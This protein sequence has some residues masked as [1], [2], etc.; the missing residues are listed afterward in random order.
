MNT[1]LYI[2]TFFGM[3]IEVYFILLLL[4][5]LTFFFWRWLLKK[6]IKA[7]RT[8]KLAT[9]TVTIVSTPLIYAGLIILWVLSMSYHPD[10]HFDKEKWFNDKEKRYEL[11]EDIIDSEML[12]GKTKTE[13]Q[14]L[15]GNEDNTKGS[16][17]WSYY[18]GFRPGFFTMDPDV[19][20]IEFKHGKVVN[21]EQHGT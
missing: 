16:N 15:L 7:D 10:H 21:V 1:L 3:S 17:S 4:G 9:W 19:L 20:D 6:F 12:I 2:P 13:V 18:L 14:Q 8:R 5:I 11:S